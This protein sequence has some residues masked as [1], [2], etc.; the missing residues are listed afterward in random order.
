MR[1]LIAPLLLLPAA[2]A[3]ASSGAVWDEFRQDVRTACRS[4][5]PEKAAVTVEVNPYGS[6][7]YGVAIVTV[8]TGSGTDRMI[9]IYDK[10]SHAA[11]LSAPFAE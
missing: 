8:D 6:E 7:R 1:L 2:S 10:A 4:L 5:V 3:A 9:C 11:E